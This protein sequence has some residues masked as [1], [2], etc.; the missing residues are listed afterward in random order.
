M[1]I[2]WLAVPSVLTAM[3]AAPASAQTPAALTAIQSAAGCA[4]PPQLAASHH[5]RDPHVMGVQ[6][7]GFRTVAGQGD[8]IVI[9]SGLR[10]GLKIDQRF[11]VRRPVTLGGSVAGFDHSISTLGWVR[12]SAVNDSMAIALVE[13]SCNTIEQGDYLEPFTEPVLPD[14]ADKAD[15]T[16]ELDFTYEGLGRLMFGDQDARTGATGDFMLVD[17]GSDRGVTPGARYAIYR[18]PI[19]QRD[20]HSAVRPYGL[21]LAAIGEAMV[22]ST[23]PAFSVVRITTARDTVQQGDYLVPRK[24]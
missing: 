6:D 9:N 11:F 12:I 19:L 15:M 24:P 21:P 14:G 8:L 7:A 18:D 5:G 20:N 17:R 1:R 4:I 13:H 16:G 23:S 22:I 2:H 3:L 10:D